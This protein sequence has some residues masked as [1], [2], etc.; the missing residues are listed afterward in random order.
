MSLTTSKVKVPLGMR[1]LDFW[2]ITSEPDNGHPVYGARVNLGAAVKGYLTVTTNPASIPGDDIDQV[3]DEIFAGAQL[4]T[5]TTM[6]DLQVNAQL[7]GHTWSAE[8]GEESKGTDRAIP[9]GL[10]FIEPIL[11]KDKVTIYR[12]TCLRK[13][14]PLASSEKQEADTRKPGE[15]NPKM[16]AVSFKI[17][18]DSL[19]SWRVRKDFDTEA[20]A[21]TF[22]QTFFGATAQSQ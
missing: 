9:G 12:V 6:S 1:T 2:P 3:W 19:H 21:Q 20:A 16:N 22:I 11:R 8:A 10:S 4:D 13:G 18:E 14:T 7:F 5:E 17:S 15:L